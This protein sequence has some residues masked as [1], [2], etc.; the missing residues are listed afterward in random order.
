MTSHDLATAVGLLALLVLTAYL[1]LGGADF[2]GGVWDLLAHGPRADAQRR[3]IS[4]AMGPV[5][6]ANHVWLIFFVVLLFT[7]FPRAFWALTI[8]LFL[9][10]HLVLFGII[11]RGASFVFRAHGN[12]GSP[13]RSAWGSVFGA[14]STVTIILLGAALAA[15]SSGGIRVTSGAV[16]A[17]PLHSW[18]SPFA[19]A[20]GLLALLV[21]AYLAAVFLTLETSGPL[22]EDFRIRAIATGAAA[23]AVALLDLPLMGSFAPHLWLRFWRPWAALVPAAAIVLAAGSLLALLSRRYRAARILSAGGVAV[24]LWGWASAE[25]PYLIYPDFT[26]GDSAAP[27]PALE[28]TLLTL[29]FGLVLLVPSLWLLLRV[30]KGRNPAAERRPR[31]AR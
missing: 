16:S 11:L 1:I 15:V 28:Q 24:L 13:V 8:A 22:R 4:S 29:P 25:W 18:L 2:G 30:F 26:L 9:P 12:L 3:A 19:V 6:E 27:T 31:E 5:W 20:T 17:D 14:G 23:T 21:A 10:L 7:G